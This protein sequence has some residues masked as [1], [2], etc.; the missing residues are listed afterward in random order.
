MLEA[1]LISFILHS[2]LGGEFI[3]DP[4]SLTGTEEQR[5]VGLR[6]QEFFHLNTKATE[7]AAQVI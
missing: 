7:L 5:A 4:Q 3:T 1:M 6:M 2:S